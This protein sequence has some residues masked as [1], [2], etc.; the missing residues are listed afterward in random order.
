MV[1]VPYFAIVAA[2]LLIFVP[3]FVVTREMAKQQGGY[4]NHDPR[5]QQTRLDGLGRRALGAHNNG[6]EAF[7]PFV[8]G[9][10][11]AAQRGVNLELA[12]ALCAAFVV[13]RSIYVAAYLSNKASLRSSMWTLGT[14]AS[15]VLL[16]SAAVTSHPSAW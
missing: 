1:Y 6:F 4:D 14:I 3:R 10:L 16:I 9:V 7:A 8:A 12:A 11:A 13:A 2:F 5:A 15:L